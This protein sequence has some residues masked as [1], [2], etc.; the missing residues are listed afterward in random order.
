M[1]QRSGFTDCKLDT[2]GTPVVG[3]ALQ[4][5]VCQGV[6]REPISGYVQFKSFALE[7]EFQ[8]GHFLGCAAAVKQNREP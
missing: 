3:F 6:L 5:E 4:I 2:Y 1:K 8:S 7:L